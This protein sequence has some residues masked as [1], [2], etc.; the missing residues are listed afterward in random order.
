MK[1]IAKLAINQLKIN[2]RRTA[3]TLIGII[4][5]AAMLTAVYGFALGGRDMMLSL[6]FETYEIIS[7]EEYEDYIRITTGIIEHHIH[8]SERFTRIFIN[9]AAILSLVIVSVSAVVVSNAFRI[10]AA[11]RLKQFGILKSVGAT[12]N[13]IRQTVLYESILLSIIGIPIGLAIGLLVQLIGVHIANHF[14]MTIAVGYVA[15]LRFI[16]SWEILLAAA[17]VSFVTV[18]ISAWLPATKAAR[19]PSIDAIRGADEVK[20]KA[21]GIRTSKLLQKIFGLEGVLA[22]KSLKRSRR[23]FR[24]TVIALSVSIILFISAAGFSNTIHQTAH[25]VLQNVTDATVA[26]AFGNY[27]GDYI[28]LNNRTADQITQI[29]REFEDTRVIGVGADFLSSHR[30]IVPRE[31]MTSTMLGYM[32]NQWRDWFEDKDGYYTFSVVL[33]TTDPKTYAELARRA[34]V[35]EGSNILINHITTMYLEQV[36][37]G[38][39]WADFVPYVFHP[40][41]LKLTDFEGQKTFTLDLHGELGRNDLPSEVWDIGAAT[42]ISILV[43][44]LDASSY[45]WF[46]FPADV[47]GFVVHANTTLY[48]QIGNKPGIHLQVLNLQ[49]ERSILANTA[50]LYMVFIYGF[51]GLLILIGLTNIISTISTNVYARSREFAVL[52][53]VGMDQKGLRRM[54]NFE[55]I[56]CSAK[57]LV[58]GLPLGILSSFFIHSMIAETVKFAYEVPWFAVIQ[59]IFGVFI[60]TWSVTRYSARKL[61]GQNVIDTI[62]SESGR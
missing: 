23:N 61:Q 6:S 44:E 19:V 3:W 49:E 42:F 45:Y 31:I 10:S 57:A 28:S 26:A 18:I 20:I 11:E 13:Q 50:R 34:G 1:L 36:N 47:N 62:R 55:S 12:K 5:S 14:L 21:K 40:Q 33:I 39:R 29:L 46:A 51:V 17:L 37:L 43:P 25:V 60:I 27:F 48:E 9:I 56:F 22:S 52:K 15:T 58:I 59:C 7:Y 32:D 30:A 16:V 54:L 2:R 38:R 24:A 53:S 41:T 8:Q 4:L 35:S